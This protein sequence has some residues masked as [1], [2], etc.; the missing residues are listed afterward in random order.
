M[1]GIRDVHKDLAVPLL[2]LLRNIFVSRKGNS[3]E[4]R[5]SL[6]SVLKESGN[7]AGTEFFRQRC[8]RLRATGVRD[9]DFDVLTREDTCERGTNLAGTNNGV[10]HNDSPAS[11]RVLSIL[12]GYLFSR[13]ARRTVGLVCQSIGIAHLADHLE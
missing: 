7:D 9:C 6:V 1:K 11:Q 12:E 10:F 3:E 8:K 5:L 2:E 13:H 4:D